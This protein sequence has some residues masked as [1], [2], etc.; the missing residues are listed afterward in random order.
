M[1]EKKKKNPT[2]ITQPTIRKALSDHRAGLTLDITDRKADGLQLRVRPTSCR[3]SVRGT[4]HGT[5]HRY[6]LGAVTEGEDALAETRQRAGRVREMLR[7]GMNPDQQVAAW[8]TGVS[9]DNQLKLFEPPKPAAA[10]SWT[11]EVAKANYCAWLLE[12]RRSATERDYRNK[13]ETVELDRF[14]GK[15]VADLTRNE[16]CQAVDDIMLRGVESQAKGCK[17]VLSAM[18]SW[19]ADGTRQEQTSVV[20]NLLL[21]WKLESNKAELGDPNAAPAV[22][23]QSEVAPAEI[24]LGR[25][26]VISRQQVFPPQQSHA[27]Q[28]WLATAQR[29]RTVLEARRFSFKSTDVDEMWEIEPFFRKSGTKR[30]RKVHLVPVVG[31]GIQAV[32][33]LDLIADGIGNSQWLVPRRGD[34]A[35]SADINLLN[36]VLD[37]MPGV[38]MSTHPCR[39][40]LGSYG[41]RDLGFGASEAELIIDH[42]E[43]VDPKDVTGSFYNLD[44]AIKRKREMLLSWTSWLEEWAARAIDADPLLLDREY[45]IEGIYRRRNG[46]EK[47]AARIA[48]RAARGMPLWPGMESESVAEASESEKQET[49]E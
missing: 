33:A 39:Y 1:P 18:W 20:P 28:L 3:W 25:V 19:L 4:L 32:K 10:P 8:L 35:K 49:A 37:D 7:A 15:R 29:R 27:V 46:D 22:V 48:Y 26:L 23:R 2:L 30:G 6:D 24:M 16:I 12:H 41:P 45:L 47:L 14:A 11:W 9:L 13:L 34:P 31:F 43:G 38:E 40:A 21:N 42:L 17:R 5:Q 44:P 36:H